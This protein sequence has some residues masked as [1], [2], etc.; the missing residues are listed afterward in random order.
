MKLKATVKS[1]R[2]YAAVTMLAT[3]SAGNANHYGLMPPPGPIY[4]YFSG[5]VTH[6]TDE[7]GIF[8]PANSSLVN[9]QF[10]AAFRGFSFDEGTYVI[11]CPE[12]LPC[13]PPIHGENIQ[14]NRLSFGSITIGDIR[15][16][17][18]FGANSPGSEVRLA[19]SIT[20]DYRVTAESSFGDA[21]QFLHF[22]VRGP[23]AQTPYLR[24]PNTISGDGIGTGSLILTQG[25][26]SGT[27]Y[28]GL[29]T[30]A[31]LRVNFFKISPTPAPEP[32]TWAM[33][34]G[35][36]GLLG[37]AVRRRKLNIAFA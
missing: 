20:A 14:P 19:N 13:N 26:Y 7:I 15:H 27:E 34:L 24:V 21:T 6:N 3:A 5:V 12:D 37:A 2:L 11:G 36:F 10:K 29:G 17:L 25:Y 30:E 1:L 32:A 31:T 4:I 18:N 33:M 9:K 35:G 28:F 22:D 23:Q 8:G 16:D